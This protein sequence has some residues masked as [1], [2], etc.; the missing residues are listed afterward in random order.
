MTNLP[1]AERPFRVLVVED[2][3]DSRDILIRRM[4][5]AGYAAIAAADVDAA[6]TALGQDPTSSCST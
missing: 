3:N 4:A 2:D 6:R 5:R 1:S